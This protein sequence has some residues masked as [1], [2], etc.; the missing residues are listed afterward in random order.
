MRYRALPVLVVLATFVIGASLWKDAYAF[1]SFSPDSLRIT[2]EEARRQRFA[3]ILDVGVGKDKEPSVGY[4]NSIPV[5]LS[6]LEEEVPYLLGDT[7]ERVR[8]SSTSRR[9]TPL[10]V[11]SNAGDGRAKQAAQRLYDLGFVGTRY[12]QESYL[13]MLPPG[14]P[15]LSHA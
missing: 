10:L 6:R 5:D 1:L 4:P 7:P 13:Q 14:Q 12:I 8:A 9:N 15:A 3:L 11:Y 2:P